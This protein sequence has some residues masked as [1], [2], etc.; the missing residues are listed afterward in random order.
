MYNFRC[1][2]S[3]LLTFCFEKP[4]FD[5]K[6]ENFILFPQTLAEPGYTF[7]FRNVLGGFLRTKLSCTS[8]AGASVHLLKQRRLPK[9]IKRRISQIFLKNLLH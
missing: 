4:G 9:V 6:A 8:Y 2:D 7:Q 3:V 5:L 1:F